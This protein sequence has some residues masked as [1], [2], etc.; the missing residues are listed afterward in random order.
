MKVR[1]IAWTQI[2]NNP[3][4]NF[5]HLKLMIGFIIPYYVVCI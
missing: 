1:Q 5:G 2:E 3:G 4:W